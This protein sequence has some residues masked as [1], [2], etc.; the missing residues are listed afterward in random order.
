MEGGVTHEGRRVEEVTPG[1]EAVGA[2]P[3]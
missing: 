1:K 2:T 3:G